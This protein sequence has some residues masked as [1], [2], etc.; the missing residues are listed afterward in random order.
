MCRSSGGSEAKHVILGRQKA[1]KKANPVKTSVYIRRSYPGLEPRVAV[2]MSGPV[3]LVLTNVL[4]ADGVDML[5]PRRGCLLWIIP[6]MPSP[7]VK[8]STHN[9]ES[10]DSLFCVAMAVICAEMLGTWSE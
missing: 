8:G 5:F 1:G 6:K 3:E 10:L 9:H 4:V 2:L 7:S